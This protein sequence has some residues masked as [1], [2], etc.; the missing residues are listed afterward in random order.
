MAFPSPAPVLLLA[1]LGA[2]P[3]SERSTCLPWS[4]LAMQ[5]DLE[6]RMA[7]VEALADVSDRK[8]M[9]DYA[10]YGGIVGAEARCNNARMDKG[11]DAAQKLWHHLGPLR[12]DP[13]LAPPTL[14]E[15][16]RGP[17]ALS[18]IVGLPEVGAWGPVSRALAARAFEA[19]PAEHEPGDPSVEEVAAAARRW[20]GIAGRWLDARR[21]EGRDGERMKTLSDALSR[22]TKNGGE[23]VD[24]TPALPA[25]ILLASQS[26][27]LGRLEEATRAF[28]R[29][30]AAE[31]GSGLRLLRAASDGEWPREATRL[32]QAG[33]G[34]RVVASMSLRALPPG[35]ALAGPAADALWLLAQGA[36][37]DLEGEQVVRLGP[38][39]ATALAAHRAA[40][41]GSF[42]PPVLVLGRA[43]PGIE[44]W[45]AA[46]AQEEGDAARVT[47]LAYDENETDLG[48]FAELVR[49]G[50]PG[51]IILAA[52]NRDSDRLLRF[53]AR[54][55]VWATRDGKPIREGE[56]HAVFIAPASYALDPGLVER[57]KDYLDGVR[58]GSDL[59]PASELARLPTVG[60][61]VER[62]G[63]YPALYAIRLAAA[64]ERA[65]D[66]VLRDETGLA[67]LQ[68]ADLAG[69]TRFGPLSLHE[70]SLTF[71]MRV[72]M[73][74]R[75][76][77]AAIAS[78]G[79]FPP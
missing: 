78:D 62:T 17:R 34:V 54:A 6:Q 76:R 52:P 21:S 42:P 46:A 67:P 31:K 45:R 73:F 7:R 23:V 22:G 36:P 69:P 20:P 77:F 33:I 11:A 48:A 29:H 35:G 27:G 50:R 15:I 38:Q 32:A 19:L 41:G 39:R 63:G 44:A 16:S 49:Q 59:P 24:A 9:E 60:S 65:E 26:G 8:A 68:A 57:N 70:G 47:A 64:L 55:G 30:A 12:L 40:L 61:F 25:A 75:G 66:A 37:A 53:L 3:A 28:L 18:L 1:L 4:V 51:T 5:P 56:I 79:Q 72:F 71:P 10:R 14:M 13:F 43:G 58:V 74:A 2:A